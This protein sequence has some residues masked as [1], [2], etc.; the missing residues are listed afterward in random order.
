[1][2]AK[3]QQQ[4]Q[5]LEEREEGKGGAGDR[6]RYFFLSTRRTRFCIGRIDPDVTF[7]WENTHNPYG[8][9]APVYL[10]AL[11]WSTFA[12]R[13]WNS[14]VTARDNKKSVSFQTHHLGVRRRN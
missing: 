14:L 13:S 3:Q 7:V 1:M 10:A 12:P 11:F 4:H 6:N 2:S 5:Q 8:S 9:G